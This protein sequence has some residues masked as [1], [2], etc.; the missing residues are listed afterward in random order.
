VHNYFVALDRLSMQQ[1]A[2]FPLFFVIQCSRELGYELNGAYSKT[3]LYLNLQEGGFTDHPPV[4]PPYC[5]DEDAKALDKLLAIQDHNSLE[6]VEMSGDMRL[7]L[8]DW[9]V[10]FLQ[11]HTQHMGNIKSLAVLRAILH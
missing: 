3:T 4:A 2:N 7:R 11:Q 8:I 5:N 9:Y 1:V 10:A 6:V